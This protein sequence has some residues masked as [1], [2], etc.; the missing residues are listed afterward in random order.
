MAIHHFQG[1]VF[2]YPGIADFACIGTDTL[3]LQPDTNLTELLTR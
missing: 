1:S 2:V 3:L